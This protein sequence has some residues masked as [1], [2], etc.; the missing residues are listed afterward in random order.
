MSN[1][2]PTVKKLSNGLE[3]IFLR[4]SSAPAIALDLWVRSGSTCET[5]NEA[6]LAHV[7][8]HMLFKGTKTRGP[9]EI[10][11][12]IENLGGEINAYTSFDHTVYTAL[13]ASRYAKAGLEVLA[14]ALFNSVFDE[15]ELFM[16]KKVVLEEIRRA[17]DLPQHCLSRNLFKSAY[18]THPYGLPVIGNEESVMGFASK[19][20]KN[21]VKKWYRPSNMTLV[22]VG[23]I[24]EEK[25]FS[26]AGQIFGSKPPAPPPRKPKIP[27]KAPRQGFRG[28]VEQKPVGEIYFDL[29]FPI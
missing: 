18:G 16:E 24:S 14:D 20:C 26:L 27:A 1:E 11:A 19:D 17:R 12:Q 9:G 10:A 4:Y 28:F 29:A 22:A 3:I 8:E 6:G 23:D 2:R 15:N 13:V 25:F 7:V 5:A 21:F